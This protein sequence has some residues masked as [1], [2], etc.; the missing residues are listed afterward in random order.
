MQSTLSFAG[1]GGGTTYAFSGRFD[2][3]NDRPLPE[4][5]GVALAALGLGLLGLSRRRRD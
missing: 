2:L 5:A 3:L 4:P 1:S